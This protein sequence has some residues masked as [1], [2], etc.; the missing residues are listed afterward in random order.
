MKTETKKLSKPA[1]ILLIDILK[2]GETTQLQRDLITSEIL[3]NC[4]RVLTVNPF[5]NDSE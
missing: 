4:I 1:K 2:A 3:N 5:R